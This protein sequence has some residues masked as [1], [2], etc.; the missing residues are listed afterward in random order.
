MS[1][2]E[3]DRTPTQTRKI[4]VL[5]RLGFDRDGVVCVAANFAEKSWLDDLVAAGFDADTPVC[6]QWEKRSPCLSNATTFV[7]EYGAGR[8][9]ERKLGKCRVCLN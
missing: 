9:H 8:G 6:F 3:I 2:S 7:G 1:R 5:D 4:A